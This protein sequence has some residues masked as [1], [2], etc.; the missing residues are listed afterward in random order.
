MRMVQSK[1]GEWRDALAQDWHRTLHSQNIR[2]NCIPND[3]HNCIKYLENADLLILSGGDDIV[4]H[5]PEEKSDDLWALRDKT[6]FSL[7]E[8]AIA[9]DLPVFGVCRGLQLINLFFGGTT[10][11]SSASENH[12]AKHHTVSITDPKA[13][14]LFPETYM[15]VNSFHSLQL[16]SLGKGLHA[17]AESDDGT[18]EG[19]YHESGRIWGIMW[20][21]ERE[22]NNKKAGQIHAQLFANLLGA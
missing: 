8:H 1:H 6:E 12:V 5:S 16:D 10:R 17:F 18:I 19:I 9:K 21:P 3:P 4:L 20:H 22:F 14:A 7:L 15:A 11:E 13:G 2:V